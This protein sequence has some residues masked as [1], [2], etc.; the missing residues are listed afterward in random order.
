[1]SRKKRDAKASDEQSPDVGFGRPPVHSRIK[2][3][4]TRNPWGRGGKPKPQKDFLEDLIELRIEGKLTKVTRDQAL[5]HFLFMQAAQGKV[6]AIR[7][8][9][10]RRLQRLAAAQAGVEQTLTADDEAALQRY[11]KRQ[12]TEAAKPVGRKSRP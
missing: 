1:M 2:A 12:E 8:L 4:E 10:A 5:D 3:G 6:A 11:L 9:E 7:Q